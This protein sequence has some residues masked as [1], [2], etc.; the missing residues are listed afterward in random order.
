MGPRR[1]APTFREG[2]PTPT[3]ALAPPKEGAR[4]AAPARGTAQT[5]GELRLA[6]RLVV[7]RASPAR[8]TLRERERNLRRDGRIL[9]RSGLPSSGG[10]FLWAAGAGEDHCEVFPGGAVP[11][12]Y[13][14]RAT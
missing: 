2:R 10:G 14:Q 8:R 9:Q 13:G 12:V 3:P 11:V 4:F 1:A 6:V 7:G 5:R